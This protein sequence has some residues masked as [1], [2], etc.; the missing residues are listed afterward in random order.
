MRRLVLSTIALLLVAS[1]ARAEEVRLSTL[2]QTE[3]EEEVL[4]ASNDFNFS[5]EPRIRLAGDHPRLVYEIEH[6]SRYNLH[7]GAS[8]LDGFRHRTI[9]N[10]TWQFDKG[11]SLTV[12]DQFSVVPRLRFQDSLDA[13]IDEVPGAGEPVEDRD[14][15]ENQVL[16]NVF[17][18]NLRGRL[19]S[20]L[21][22]A[23]GVTHFYRKFDD[24]SFRQQ[25]TDALSTSTSL[26]WRHSPR[27][28]FGAGFT[29]RRRNFSTSA[30]R[31]SNTDTYNAYATWSWVV[32]PR[33]S[34]QAR[35]GP[36]WSVD[37][38]G[39]FD[40]PRYGTVVGAPNRLANPES[41]ATTFLVDT[42]MGPSLAAIL[43]RT[44]QADPGTL[45]TPNR[46]LTPEEAAANQDADPL[47]GLLLSGLTAADLTDP[48]QE[49]NVNVFFSFALSRVWERFNSTVTYR[50][51]DS[52]TQ[53]LGA[54]TTL[55]S[56]GVVTRWE[57][58]AKFESVLSFF[59]TR[60]Q[61][62]S[63]QEVQIPFFGLRQEGMVDIFADEEF[64]VSPILGVRT[65]DRTLD[66]VDDIFSISLRMNRKMTR[67]SSAFVSAGMRW[68]ERK[69]DSVVDYGPIELENSTASSGND[70]EVRWGFIYHFDPIQL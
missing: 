16:T 25:D 36:A 23:V 3:Y 59:W 26:S 67:R 15:V 37:E 28:T 60:R 14:L 1:T 68:T 64:T 39:E 54:A 40:L 47:P 44:C 45:A 53:S 4:G 57:P 13:T 69:F 22:G 63:T 11:R 9:A 48:K 31:D 30:I 21:T 18:A 38:I 12:N 33:T 61:S 55:D 34:F 32:D 27:H 29:F 66:A 46:D 8:D 24:P 49:T 20:R 52:E 2:F 56:L 43:D 70:W 7:T 19:F 41:C 51:S 42:G 65:F 58:T 5:F 50:R 62:D 6:A 17:S 35:I 10:G